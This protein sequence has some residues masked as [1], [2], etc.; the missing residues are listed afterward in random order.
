MTQWTDVMA[1]IAERKAELEAV[2]LP[3]SETGRLM[4][5]AHL[6]ELAHIEALLREAPECE[7]SYCSVAE[8]LKEIREREEGV[9]KE[10]ELIATSLAVRANSWPVIRGIRCR[11]VD[12]NGKVVWE[13]DV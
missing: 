7:C 10:V 3:K 5:F 9:Q 8:T 6:D 12:G 13:D 4:L 11:W 1:L 2:R